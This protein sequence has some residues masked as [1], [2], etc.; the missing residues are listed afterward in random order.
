MDNY[1]SSNGM[2]GTAIEISFLR[3]AI[4]LM[5][6]YIMTR[7]LEYIA[8][9]SSILFSTVFFKTHAKCFLAQR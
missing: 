7:K 1:F 6:K 3:P 5:C 8:F 4:L 2:F 9:S